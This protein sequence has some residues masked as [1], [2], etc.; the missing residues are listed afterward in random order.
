KTFTAV[1]LAKMA[2]EGRVRLDEPVRALLPPE[3]VAAP[4]A[5]EITLLDLATHRS[6]LP[7]MPFN[8]NMAAK[9]NPGAHYTAEHLYQFL[10]VQGLA[11]PD[12]A[13]FQYSN[14][15]FGLLGTA[16]A[17]RTGISYADLLRQE[18]TAPLGLADTGL[19][20]SPER[21]IQAY[22]PHNQPIA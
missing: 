17:S 7:G 9:P 21:V 20:V 19:A 16:L 22:D 6:G 18:I 2:A 1:L 10:A 14:L 11:R 5:A 12:G 4:Q 13:P 15:G 3:A 8:L